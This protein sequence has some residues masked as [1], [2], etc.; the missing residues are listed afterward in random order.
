M[1]VVDD[2]LYLSQA[3]NRLTKDQREVVVLRYYAGRSTAEIAVLL[4]KNERA[5]YSAEARAMAAL[6]SQLSAESDNLT[7]GRDEIRPAPGIDRIEGR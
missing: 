3:L 7:P 1:D 6:R 5:V 2:A 4:G